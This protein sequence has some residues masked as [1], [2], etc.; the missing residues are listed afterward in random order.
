[1]NSYSLKDSLKNIFWCMLGLTLS[2]GWII[3]ICLF[4]AFDKEEDIWIPIGFYILIILIFSFVLEIND[5]IK[6]INNNFE[7]EKGFN[8]KL[9]NL[10]KEKDD[11]VNFYN[12]EI[13]KERLNLDKLY[14]DKRNLLISQYNSKVQE[15]NI[16][17]KKLEKLYNDK[18]NKL[19][20]K[21]SKLSS[22]LD[23][24]KEKFNK[25]VSDE[26]IYKPYLAEMIA[27]YN[28]EYEMLQINILETKKN[29]AIKKANE[30]KE[31]SKN[32]KVL[33]RELKIKEHQLI[34][35]ESLFPWLEEFKEIP[36]KEIQEIINKD[37]SEGYD[38]VKEFLSPEEYDKLSNLEK[39]Q[40]W[41]DR[42][43]AKSNKSKWEIGVEFER[44]VGYKYESQGYKLIY[45][46]ARE[47]LEDLGRDLIATK[48]KEILIIQCKNWSKT[49]IIHEKHI[50]QLYGTMILK[51]IEEPN[52]KIRGIFI[53]TTK[54]SDIAKQVANRL[55]ITVLEN[56]NYDKNYPC[57]KC[58]ISRKDGSK[59]YH[60]PF[61]QQYDRIDVEVKRGECYVSTV[62]EAEN[63][64]FRKAMKYNFYD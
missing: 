54:L 18:K 6:K 26:K 31:I 5:L 60:L 39:Y 30:L 37:I 20:N 25:I 2:Y 17:K 35:Y 57:I 52:K 61:D 14:D 59:I 63:L 23:N 36:E 19:V 32:N 24:E 13:Q 10:K 64:G 12:Q 22:E 43:R 7:S 55:N 4:A 46:G 15:V 62:L 38:R 56:Y 47:G 42:Y 21:Y 16:E 9:N 48:D 50:F 27:K 53:T 40:L 49:K 51:S 44:Y 11:L 3:A 34:V 29:P 8:T 33:K 41:L 58:N 1:M 45:N 28:E